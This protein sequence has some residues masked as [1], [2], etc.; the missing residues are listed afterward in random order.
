MRREKFRS[1]KNDDLAFALRFI[2][3]DVFT[4][5]PKSRFVLMRQTL[6]LP[7]FFFRKLHH[8]IVP[9]RVLQ[10]KLYSREKN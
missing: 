8:R 2:F 4:G 1:E 9:V 10:N 6:K 3:I 7:S 5:N